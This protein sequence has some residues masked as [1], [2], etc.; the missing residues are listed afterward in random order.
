MA[1][2]GPR[3]TIGTHPF[4]RHHTANW[5]WVTWPPH[6]AVFRR[7]RAKFWGWG[8]TSVSGPQPRA[9][10]A[11]AKQPMFPPTSTIMSSH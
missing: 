4:A 9:R 6:A 1:V 7:A 11:T 3:S 10:H 2:C 8:S 5:W